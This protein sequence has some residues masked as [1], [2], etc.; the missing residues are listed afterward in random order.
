MDQV[1]RGGSHRS[2]VEGAVKTEKRLSGQL[3]TSPTVARNVAAPLVKYID[4]VLVADRVGVSE[5]YRAG[6]A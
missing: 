3:F 4:K 1:A 5:G 2:A 6:G